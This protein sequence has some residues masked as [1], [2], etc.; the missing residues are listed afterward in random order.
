MMSGWSNAAADFDNDGWKDLF[1]ARGNVIDNIALMSL[2]K[3]EEPNTVFRNLGGVKFEDVSAAAG[4]EDAA[5]HRGVAYG[6]LDNDGR[7]DMVVTVLNGPA[8]Y[9]RNVGGGGNH[10]LLLKLDGVKSNRMGIGARVRITTPDGKRQY[11]HATTSSGYAGSSDVRVH[12][13]LGASK[14]VKEI[15]VLWPSGIRQVLQ[16]VAADQILTVTEK[17]IPAAR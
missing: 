8:K 15:E 14:V 3:Y 13:G 17:G 9:L 6:D 2:R 5:P 7:I 12:F 16:N 11:N 4:V 1:V 10:W